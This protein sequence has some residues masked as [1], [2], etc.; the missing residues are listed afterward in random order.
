MEGEDDLAD[1]TIGRLPVS[2]SGDPKWT[3][4]ANLPDLVAK[5]LLYDRYP[6]EGDWYSEA[7]LAGVYRDELAPNPDHEADDFFMETMVYASDF[8]KSLEPMS[9]ETALCVSD[10]S[11]SG[12]STSLS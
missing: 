11:G 3:S 8:L 12:L 6:V 7:L 10:H 2:I 5:I 4:K 1:L 9:V